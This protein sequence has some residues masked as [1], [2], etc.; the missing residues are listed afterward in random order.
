MSNRLLSIIACYN[1]KI[2][3][4]V[5]SEHSL[6][7]SRESGGESCF[8]RSSEIEHVFEKLTHNDV[9]TYLVNLKNKLSKLVWNSQ[10]TNIENINEYVLNN[11]ILIRSNTN[12]VGF[13]D[14]KFDINLYSQIFN[15]IPSAYHTRRKDVTDKKVEIKVWEERKYN[16]TSN[17]SRLYLSLREKGLS[18]VPEEFFEIEKQRLKLMKNTTKKLNKLE[19][20]LN[21]LI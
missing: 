6:N 2:W 9:A 20:R 5:G 14:E 21:E 8:Y 7:E 3:L 12:L 10:I 13:D 18:E 11:G 17:K 16:N 1:D 19:D 15:R 4:S